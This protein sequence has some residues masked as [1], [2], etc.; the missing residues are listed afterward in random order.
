MSEGSSKASSPSNT[1][2][3]TNSDDILQSHV[4]IHLPNAN[5]WRDADTSQVN[6]AP[7]MVV[8]FLL[9]G[10]RRLVKELHIN[11]NMREVLE[12]LAEDLHCEPDQLEI[13]EGTEPVPDSLVLAGLDLEQEGFALS[14]LERLVRRRPSSSDRPGSGA[15]EPR[16][17]DTL[18]VHT[19]SGASRRT[20]TVSLERCTG[21]KPFLGGY[22]DKRNGQEYLNASAQ[23]Y[24]RPY[25]S[26][27]HERRER[28]AQTAWGLQV[29]VQTCKDTCTQMPKPGVWNDHAGERVV[30][31][32]GA[33]QT[34]EQLM[35]LRNEKAVVLQKCWRRWL[36]RRRVQRMRVERD[37]VMQWLVDDAER[38]R[39]ARLKRRHGLVERKMDPKTK[40]DFD[41]LFSALEAWRKKAIAYCYSTKSGGE[42]KAALCQLL[43]QEAEM[44]KAIHGHQNRAATDGQAKRI[45]RLLKEMQAPHRWVGKDGRV[46]EVDNNMSLWARQLRDIHTAMTLPDLTCS[47]R[48]DILSTL[49]TLIGGL[50]FSAENH[51]LRDLCKREIDLLSRGVAPRH[52]A[53]LRQRALQLFW[54]LLRDV[55]FNPASVK[56]QKVPLDPESIRGDV[57]TCMSCH[58][59]LPRDQFQVNAGDVTLRRCRLC[60]QLENWA[61]RRL[62]NNVL[63]LMLAELRRDEQHRSPETAAAC[64]IQDS[65]FRHLVLSLWGGQSCLSADPDLYELVLCRWDVAQPW[66]PWNCVLLTR[67]EAE[68]HYKLARPLERYGPEQCQRVHLRHVA[69]GRYFC[70]LPAMMARMEAE[71]SARNAKEAHS[72]VDSCR[73]PAEAPRPGAAAAPV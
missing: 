47:E 27:S 73:G 17:P 5:Q 31:Y 50:P 63:G 36:C 62:D 29:A 32:S 72:Q 38:R 26:Y 39:L 16:L 18:T 25:R 61:L 1:E 71:M 53:G 65:D 7:K 40:N 22:R 23:T 4:D 30:T 68:A 12:L 33:Y 41:V 48:A 64:L 24:T 21:R 8:P 56:H 35:Q 28:D 57:N 15:S 52:L 55:N 60:D 46:M 13:Y 51:E 44:L 59:C 3:P 58:R 49:V 9:P 69:A 43:E 34:A 14:V 11:Y 37:V 19:G 45:N 6:S 20:V 2:S 70:H 54:R 66:T 67:D 42:L 10:G